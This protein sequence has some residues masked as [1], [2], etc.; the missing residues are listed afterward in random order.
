L[1]SAEHADALARRIDPVTPLAL[2]D[3]PASEQGQHTT[4]LS[5]V[6]P[7]GMAVSLTQSINLPFGSGKVVPG[8]GILL[9]DEMD[10]F[11]AGSANAFGLVGN[12]KNAPRAGKRPLSS[13]APTMIFDEQGLYAV[14]GSPG[15]SQ[16]PSAVASVIRGL[17]EDGLD[18]G[19]AIHAPRIHHQWRPDHLEFE[20]PAPQELP[21]DL[22][23]TA[24]KARFP[25][26][27]IQLIVRTARGLRAVS[28][29]RGTGASWSEDLKAKSR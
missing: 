23:P 6:A 21:S 5:V 4:H 22:R 1:V 18:P 25:I 14:V 2:P 3:A 7:D 12:E 20:E 27:N 13:M 26:G 8:T 24:S 28:D 19:A 15:G 17:L 16:I 29:C 9:N 10:D 11:F